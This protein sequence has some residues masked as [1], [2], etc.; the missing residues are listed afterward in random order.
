MV[1]RDDLRLF[2][3]AENAEEVWSRLVAG[4]LKLPQAKRR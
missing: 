3:F 1:D 2:S 4:G